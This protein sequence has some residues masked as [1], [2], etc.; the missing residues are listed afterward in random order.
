[1]LTTILF[2]LDGT[3]LP[4]E[5]KPFLDIYFG[6]LA[7]RFSTFGLDSKTIIAAIWK[8][9][10][11][12]YQNT[13]SQTNEQAFWDSFESLGGIQTIPRAEFDRFYEEE[14]DQVQAS[15]WVNPLSRKTLD[16]LKEKGYQAALATNPIFPAIATKKRI[17]WAGLRVEDFLIVTTFENSH[18]TKP[19][20]AYY[21]EVLEQIGKSPSECLMVGND[22]TED[23]AA[24]KAGIPVYLI[25]DCLINEHNVDLSQKK[26]GTFEEFYQFVQSLP[27][28]C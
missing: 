2:D 21:Q 11:A 17:G 15:S 25:T 28:L 19:S 14:F 16:L 27:S 1:M 9:T 26:K 6:L 10:E 18:A 24:E 22:A 7:K 5:E 4:L 13:G 3:L 20:K 12:M 8:S 23:V